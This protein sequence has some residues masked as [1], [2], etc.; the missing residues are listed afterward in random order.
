[1]PVVEGVLYPCI[2]QS[3]FIC[4]PDNNMG[5]LN[6]PSYVHILST[7]KNGCVVKSITIVSMDLPH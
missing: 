1:M 5:E 3:V 6:D 2:R 7:Q 4:D